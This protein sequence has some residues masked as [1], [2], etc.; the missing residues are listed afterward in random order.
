MSSAPQQVVAEF[1]GGPLD[2]E[3]AALPDLRHAWLVPRPP[4]MPTVW[5]DPGET[6]PAVAPPCL[7]YTLAHDPLT[8]RPSIND[9][10]RYRYEFG[11]YR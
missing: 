6:I 11:G 7:V 3:V 2:G 5:V 9:A 8:G 1:Y 10:G 4:S